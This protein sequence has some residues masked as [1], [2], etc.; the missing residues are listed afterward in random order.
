MLHAAVSAQREA[1][2]AS[3]HNCRFPAKVH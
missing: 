1:P 2:A 3:A